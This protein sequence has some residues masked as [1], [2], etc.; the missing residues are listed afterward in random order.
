MAFIQQ[1]LMYSFF[2][3]ALTSMFL[4]ILSPGLET[5]FSGRNFASSLTTGLLIV[6]ENPLLLLVLM[7]QLCIHSKDKHP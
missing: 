1:V 7:L 3:Y 6:T 4:Y 5:I 2:T